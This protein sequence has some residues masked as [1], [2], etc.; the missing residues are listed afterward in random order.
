[1]LVVVEHRDVELVVQATLD[2]EAPWSGDVLD[3]HPAEGRRGRLDEGDDL[4]DV[5][6]GDA[7]REGVDAREFLEQQRLA[8]HDRHRGLRTDVAEAQDRRPV[9]HDRDRVALDGQPPRPIGVLVNRRA[10]PGDARGVGRREVV[11]RLDGT[12]AITSILPP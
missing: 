1:V 3:V 9:G 5:A 11:P 4:V 12:R 7:Q 2:L 8:L 10:D 6:R